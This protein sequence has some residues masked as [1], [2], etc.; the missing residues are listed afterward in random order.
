MTMTNRKK[1]TFVNIIQK[2]PLNIFN[3]FQRTYLITK[4]IK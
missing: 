4:K 2:Y 3:M 1:L